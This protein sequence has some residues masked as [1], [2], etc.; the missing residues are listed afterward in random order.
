M[1]IQSVTISRSNKIIDENNFFLVK[2]SK[3]FEIDKRKNENMNI[4]MILI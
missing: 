3:V 2:R 4:D 1:I